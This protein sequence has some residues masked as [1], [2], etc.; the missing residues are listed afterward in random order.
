MSMLTTREED[1]F[2]EMTSKKHG[3]EKLFEEINPTKPAPYDMDAKSDILDIHDCPMYQ[4][5]F[6]EEAVFVGYGEPYTRMMGCKY[7][8]YDKEKQRWYDPLSAGIGEIPPNRPC[9]KVCKRKEE[10]RLEPVK[11]QPVE[12]IVYGRQSDSAWDES[13]T[14]VRFET[15]D[16]ESFYLQISQSREDNMQGITLDIEEWRDLKRA[17]D[18]QILPTLNKQNGTDKNL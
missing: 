6:G 3:E 10:P 8:T 7:L 14:K 18:T 17:I 15:E 2:Y 13:N 9:I 16:G 11:C 4:C 12:W 5:R 1:E